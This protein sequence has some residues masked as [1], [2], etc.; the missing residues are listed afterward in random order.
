MGE[1]ELAFWYRE[2]GYE[3]AM[4]V[5]EMAEAFAGGDHL[6]KHYETVKEYRESLCREDFALRKSIE[7]SEE[8]RYA[9]NR[10]RLGMILNRHK[11][12]VSRG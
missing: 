12:R 3:R 1:T 10:A 5:I 2:A 6:N 4:R 9:A 8:E 7:R 11:N